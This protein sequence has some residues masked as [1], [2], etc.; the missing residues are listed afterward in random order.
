MILLLLQIS[1]YTVRYNN[2][3]DNTR[4][5]VLDGIW[6]VHRTSSY[7]LSSTYCVHA[8][9][10]HYNLFSVSAR[11]IQFQCT[12][13]SEKSVARRIHARRRRSSR[14]RGPIKCSAR[15]HRRRLKLWRAREP[16]RKVPER[17]GQWGRRRRT[18]HVP[19]RRL[20]PPAPR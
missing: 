9:Y 11:L 13:Q 3:N 16:V 8:Q 4:H 19:R 20:H 17:R 15:S 7:P 18:Q 10:I 5:T 6:H 12:S 14:H 1:Q 2:N